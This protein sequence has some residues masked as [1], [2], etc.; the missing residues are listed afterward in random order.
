M[1][2]LAIVSSKELL[3][4]RN[5]DEQ[6]SFHAA[7]EQQRKQQDSTVHLPGI[8]YALGHCQHRAREITREYNSIYMYNNSFLLSRCQATLLRLLTFTI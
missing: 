6:W 3:M 5:V 4:K 8:Y 2:K 1:L 7:R